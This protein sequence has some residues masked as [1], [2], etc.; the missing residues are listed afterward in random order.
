MRGKKKIRYID[1][2][3]ALEVTPGMKI[4]DGK[5]AGT[6]GYMAPEMEARLPYSCNADVWSLG[7]VLFQV[8]NRSHQARY[9]CLP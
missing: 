7:V 6:P 5:R 8:T 9:R 2:G 3:F 4:E 1:F